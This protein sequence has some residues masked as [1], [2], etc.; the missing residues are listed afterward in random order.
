MNIGRRLKEERER[1]GMNQT[2]FAAIAG[3]SKHAQ[4]NWE[5]GEATPNANALAAWAEK[6]LDVLYVVTGSR[7][8]T[9]PSPTSSEHQTIIRDYD[10]SSPD[11]KEAIRRMAAATALGA[12]AIAGGGRSGAHGSRKYL[13]PTTHQEFHESAPIVGQV[14]T[15]KPRKKKS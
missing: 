10:A 5:K 3:A 8:F 13:G 4:I 12:A 14:V 9:P 11:G 1:L 15:T 7:S 2:G 6:G